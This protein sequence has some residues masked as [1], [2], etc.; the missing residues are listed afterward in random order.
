MHGLTTTHPEVPAWSPSLRCGCRSWSPRSSFS[1]PVHCCTWCCPITTA[2][3]AAAERRGRDGRD[4]QGR[5]AARRLH[6][7]ARRFEGGLKDPAF[8][9]KFA[10]GPVAM[11]TVM[12]SGPPTM[13]RQ[14]AQWFCTASWW[15]SS[16]RTSRAAHSS[17]APTTWPC[18]GSPA[19]P[20][21]SATRWRC[22]RTRFVQEEVEHDDQEHDRRLD[23]RPADRRHVRV[24]LAAMIAARHATGA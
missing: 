13:G 24:A 5:C 2:T 4:A 23:L 12:R 11:L 18:F 6:D 14:L 15:A 7:A 20:P 10:K 9:D 17:L 16:R 22:G 8:L 3:T 19:R 21:S 1:S